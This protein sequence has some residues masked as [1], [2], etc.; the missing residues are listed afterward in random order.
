MFRKLLIA[1]LVVAMLAGGLALYERQRIRLVLF[2]RSMFSG[3]DQTH[4]FRTMDDIFPISVVK[5]GDQVFEFERGESI[6]LPETY[7]S[8]GEEKKTEDFIRDI[9]VT[10]LIVIKDDSILYEQYF[11]GN[12]AGTRWI[13]WS[14]VKS[15]ISALVG[16]AIEDGHID[17]VEDPIT[18]YVPMLDGSGYDGVSIEHILEMSSGVRWDETYAD[19]QSDVNRMGRT[20]AFG[21]SFEDFITTLVPEREP[22]SYRRYNS[23][24]TLALGILVQR[25]TGRSVSE[26]LSDKIWSRIGMEH[27]AYF[28]TDRTGIELSFG[29]LNATL[30][31]YAKFGRL[32]LERGNWNGE[33]IVSERWVMEST[34]ATKPHR[35]PGPSE[36]TNSWLGY[37]YQWW[38][39]AGVDGEFMAIGVYNQ[40]IYV[41]RKLNLIIARTGANPRFGLSESEEDNR[42]IESLDFLRNIAN[43]LGDQRVPR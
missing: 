24:D 22:G 10:G 41:N 29:G 32:F 2:A 34:A 8:H 30:R 6:E 11:N 7:V 1:L 38:V 35:R 25:A 21:S 4:N 33:Q 5:R 31:D 16:I 26:Y 20:L 19:P 15:V 17:S 27:D 9:N 13:S 28:I 40:V 43:K 37:G 18:K 36:L 3:A 39:P 12:D 14:M 23:M 42:H